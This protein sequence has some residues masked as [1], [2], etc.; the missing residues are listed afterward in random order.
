MTA[1]IR[2]SSII[3]N[4]PAASRATARGI[5]DARFLQRLFDEHVRGKAN[6]DAFLTSVLI[7]DLWMYVYAK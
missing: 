7:F 1:G 3:E 4:N 2:L 6:H 5:F